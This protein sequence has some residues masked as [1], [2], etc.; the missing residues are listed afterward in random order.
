MTRNVLALCCLCACGLLPAEAADGPV[1]GTMVFPERDGVAVIAIQDTATRMKVDLFKNTRPDYPMKLRLPP[2]WE[3]SVNVFLVRQAGKSYLVDAGNAPGRGSLAAKLA[4][5]GVMPEQI[6]GVLITHIHPDHVGG[7]LAGGG[8]AA[9]TVAQFP[10][11]ALYI[12]R[13]E[14]DAWKNDESRQALGRFLEPYANRLQLFAFGDTLPGG[15]TARKTAGHTPGHTLFALDRLWFIG[16]LVHAAGLQF[17][18]PVFCARYDRDPALAVKTRIDVMTEAARQDA[19]VLGAHIPFPG[20]GTVTG[21]ENLPGTTGH[22]EW[23]HFRF[24][25]VQDGKMP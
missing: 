11:A 10:R 7:L 12:A 2:D 3:A 6:D 22:A 13:E 9:V 4:A 23:T 15:F 19:V 24:L 1:A 25:P 14:Y 18:H 20:L 21:P 17:R 16:D 8:E 5:L